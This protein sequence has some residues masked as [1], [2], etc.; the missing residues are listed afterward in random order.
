MTGMSRAA[1]SS[2]IGTLEREGLVARKFSVMDRRTREV[3]LTDVGLETV[4]SVLDEH[5][6]REQLWASAL[7]VAEQRELVRLLE[8]LASAADGLG[9]NTR[10]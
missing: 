1:V 10:D 3:S 4:D 9:V 2:L 8:K 7:S 5:N 6:R